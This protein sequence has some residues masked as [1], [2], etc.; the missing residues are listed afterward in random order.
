MKSI[1]RLIVFT[2]VI[3]NKKTTLFFVVL[4]SLLFRINNEIIAIDL[5]V[6]KMI[7]LDATDNLYHSKGLVNSYA[8]TDDISREINIPLYIFPPGLSLFTC[9]AYAFTN[10]LMLASILVDIMSMCL[11]YFSLL[12]L[13]G[14]LNFTRFAKIV[15]FTFIAFTV[16]PFDFLGSS[17]LMSLSFFLF[18]IAIYFKYNKKEKINFF[19]IIIVCILA[20]M[21]AF[22][23]FAY[24]P[25]VFILP[26]V[27]ALSGLLYKKRKFLVEGIIMGVVIMILL[28][29]LMLWIKTT[30]GKY[31]LFDAVTLE[32]GFYLKNLF[33]FDYFPFGAF[34]FLNKLLKFYFLHIED[35]R[36]ILFTIFSAGILFMVFKLIFKNLKNFFYAEKN[37]YKFSLYFILFAA[38]LL[39]L[40]ELSYLSVRYPIYIENAAKWIP[41][42]TYVSD[43]RYWAVSIV[44]I[45]ILI[46]G[47]AFNKNFNIN[48]TEKIIS[49]VFVTVSIIFSIY[50]YHYEAGRVEA[51]K[52]LL[53]NR[54][55]S[56]D[57]YIHRENIP[58]NKMIALVNK[59]NIVKKES[60]VPVLFLGHHQTIMRMI[61]M[62]CTVPVI[63]NERI[64]KN[65]VNFE[66]RN[67]SYDNLRTS[68]DVNLL[69]S[70]SMLSDN[71]NEAMNF[72][73]KQKNELFYEL[74]D[75]TTVYKIYFKKNCKPL[76]K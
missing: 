63:D 70:V 40:L 47:I 57:L 35:I 66:M 6:D 52:Q 20:F 5:S 74:S 61:Q 58:K 48:K 3:L 50:H 43:Q 16:S 4:I 14:L 33:Y 65:N 8:S 60:K 62:F 68:K 53:I 39:N 27:I 67:D 34:F 42:W 75:E 71:Y 72:L 11:L 73:K 36:R 17:D 9:V 51:T 12:I 76:I 54:T 23:R 24:Y 31:D 41:I 21:P 1:K 29:I 38:V 69:L 37:I 10:D 15:F 45:Q 28:L 46:I 25:S 26:A 56:P 22:A 59:I 44:I 55:F 32:K 64:K 7:Q 49:A 13:L 2:N 18:S 30:S 19:L